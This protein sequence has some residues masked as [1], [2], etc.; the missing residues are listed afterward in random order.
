MAQTLVWMLVNFVAHG[1]GRVFPR[2][3]PSKVGLPSAGKSVPQDATMR[4]PQR[5][6]RRDKS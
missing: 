5:R 1:L 4:I 2:V 6:E 3:R